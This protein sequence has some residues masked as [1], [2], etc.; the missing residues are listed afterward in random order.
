M[1]LRLVPRR[2]VISLSGSIGF[3]GGERDGL[4][5]GDAAGGLHV[6]THIV[7]GALLQVV[8]C[9]IEVARFYM[10][11]DATAIATCCGLSIRCA[12]ADATLRDR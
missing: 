12:V 2:W 1:A 5:V 7:I 10:G 3:Q 11:I 9:C 8:E 6:W 4:S